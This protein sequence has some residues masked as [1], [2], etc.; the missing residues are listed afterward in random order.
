M[1]IAEVS[2]LSAPVCDRHG[3]SVEGLVWLLSDRLQK[4]GHEVTVFATADSRPPCELVATLPAPYGQAGAPDDWQLCEWINL[5]R[6]VEASEDFDVIHTHAYLWGLPLGPLSACPMVHTMHVH[7]YQDSAAL[8]RA[9]PG[10]HVAALTVHQWSEFPDLHPAAVIP[11]GVDPLCH[12][13]SAKPSDYLCFLGRF[14]P[15]KGPLA[16]IAA[17]RRLEMPLRIAGPYNDYYRD[18]VEPL[19]DGELVRYVGYVDRA[20]R[21]E[22]LRGARA[23]LY[24]VQAPEPFG[25]VL[26]EAMLSG[27]PVAALGQGA[28]PE[29]VEEGITGAWEPPGGDVAA[30]VR[31]CLALERSRVRARAVERFSPDSMGAAYEAVFERVVGRVLR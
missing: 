22:L 26:V 12:S 11:H 27:T 3:A 31:R 21:D 13:F 7:P 29:L 15:D 10:A 24:P 28:V 1:R 9:Y 17:A 20:Q 30:A 8:W 4:R 23:L 16:A 25:L 2:T 18:Q 6:A 19:V 5:C 14:T